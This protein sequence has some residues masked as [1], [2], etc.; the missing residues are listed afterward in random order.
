MNFFLG[1]INVL[2]FGLIITDLIVTIVVFVINITRH[3]ASASTHWHLVFTVLWLQIRPLGTT[4]GQPL[5]F[6]Q[7]TSGSVQ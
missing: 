6:L 1:L 5:P 4:R 2:A 7:L 3:R